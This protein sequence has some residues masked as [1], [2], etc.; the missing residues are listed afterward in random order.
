[1]N[2]R[3][4][5]LTPHDIVVNRG[6]FKIT[7]PPERNPVRVKHEWSYCGTLAGIDVVET[8]HNNLENVPLPEEGTIFVVST[9]AAMLLRRKDV[10][11][12]DTGPTATRSSGKVMSITRFQRYS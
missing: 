3:L 12:P 11:A 2:Q 7:L 8:S 4:V 1:M 10:V 9:L 6:G 5:N